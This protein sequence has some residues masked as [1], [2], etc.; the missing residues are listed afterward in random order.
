MERPLRHIAFDH[1]PLLSLC[2][3][4]A[5]KHQLITAGLV[6]CEICFCKHVDD[7]VVEILK[8]CP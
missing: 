2:F 7:M 1:Q 8:A 3:K 4:V 6:F 5:G